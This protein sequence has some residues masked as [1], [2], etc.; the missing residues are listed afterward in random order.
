MLLP[1]R[2][3]LVGLQQYTNIAVHDVCARLTLFALTVWGLCRDKD[4][5]RAVNVSFGQ[6]PRMRGLQASGKARDIDCS[7][8]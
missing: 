6:Q 3:P 5:G 4:L 7:S 2:A 1:T 8:V